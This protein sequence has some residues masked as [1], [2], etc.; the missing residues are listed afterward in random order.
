MDNGTRKGSRGEAEAKSVRWALY[1]VRGRV[2]GFLNAVHRTVG[3]KPLPSQQAYSTC[4]R[5][6]LY[7][8]QHK[9]CPRV[10]YV[11]NMLIPIKQPVNVLL[12]AVL[13]RFQAMVC[14]K[15][16][17]NCAKVIDRIPDCMSRCMNNRTRL[18]DRMAD[19]DIPLVVDFLCKGMAIQYFSPAVQWIHRQNQKPTALWSYGPDHG[20][21]QLSPASTPN[22]SQ[23][24][25]GFSFFAAVVLRSPNSHESP[26]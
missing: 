9:L 5:H 18:P 11:I 6:R 12:S 10:C 15:S 22:P 4:K 17:N 24:V 21:M 20:A 13:N 7:S 3:R 1:L 2:H 23:R 26:W 8:I 25:S 16:V 19:C 14:S